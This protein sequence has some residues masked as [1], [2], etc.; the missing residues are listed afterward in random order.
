MAKLVSKQL[1]LPVQ[2]ADNLALSLLG[3]QSVREYY[4][5]HGKDAF[6]RKQL[7]GLAAYAGDHP[8]L[9]ISLGGGAVEDEALME[10][11]KGTGK[12]IY[13]RREENDMFP[14]VIEHGIPA[15]L[16]PEDLEGSFHKVYLKR[17]SLNLAKADLVINLGPYGDKQETA[18][19][20]ISALK[21]AGYVELDR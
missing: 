21:E 18:E 6:N 19:K 7:E 12:L 5:E 17:D 1:G 15:F 4:R 14:F 20:I 16:D 13:L 3:G 11:V 9:I 10:Y 2:D 8:D